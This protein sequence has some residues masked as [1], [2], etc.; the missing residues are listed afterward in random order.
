MSTRL[1]ECSLSGEERFILATQL[2]QIT[3]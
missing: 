2:T 1:R 3:I